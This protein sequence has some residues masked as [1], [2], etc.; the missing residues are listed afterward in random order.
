[1]LSLGGEPISSRVLPGGVSLHVSAVDLPVLLLSPFPM[2]VC[3]KAILRF[4]LILDGMVGPLQF[5]D[6][7]LVHRS[8]LLALGAAVGLDRRGVTGEL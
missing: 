4:G 2:A 3:L 6:A 7:G 8:V 1:M 5:D